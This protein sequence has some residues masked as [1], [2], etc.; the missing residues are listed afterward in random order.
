[1]NPTQHE[2][3]YALKWYNSVRT[4]LFVAFSTLVGIIAIFIYLY[5]PARLRDQALAGIKEQAASFGEFLAFTISPAIDLDDPASGETAMEAVQLNEVV[6][7][8][9]VR[10]K[11][12]NL[13]T[14]FGDTTKSAQAQEAPEEGM[15]SVDGN[16][17]LT[18]TPVLHEKGYEVGRLYVGHSLEKMKEDVR[19][20]QRVIALISFLIFIVGVLVVYW[21]SS[22]LTRNLSDIVTVV[23][24]IGAGDFS[25]RAVV[26]SQD[27][28]GILATSF[29][30]M[31]TDLG[32]STLALRKREE[33][34]RSL[35]ESMNEG[36][37][38]MEADLTIRYANPRLC[39]MLGR[40]EADLV[41][42]HLTVISGDMELP[43]FQEEGEGRQIELQLRD[44]NDQLLWILLSYSVAQDHAGAV[45]IT[46]IFTDITVLKKTERD[47]VYKNRELDTFVYKAS[48]DLKAPLSSLS[49]LVDIAKSDLTEDPSA[50]QYLTLIQRTVQKMDDVLQGLLE[51][52]WIKQGAL[53]P[54]EIHVADLVQTILRSI[55]HAPGYDTVTFQMEIPER[56]QIVSD[57]K[58][59]N[60]ILQN[61]I[62]N[63]V[64]YH[65]DEGDDKWVSI[66]V[67][68]FPKHARIAIR[69]NGPGIP[70]AAQDR[71]FDMFYRASNKSKG[72]GLGLYIVKT[73]IEKMGG[74]VTLTSELGVGTEFVVE[75][76]KMALPTP[77][78]AQA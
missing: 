22:L 72:S 20:S 28:V 73:S 70:A 71:L 35:A 23:H 38:Q 52:T 30:S 63:A 55:E 3:T 8:V 26:A 7:F 51:V 50:Q 47:L 46:A 10:D 37:L 27:E 58:I 76:P 43:D 15:L 2:P 77:T 4:R 78:V 17:W 69:D 18:S 68:D 48:H 5:F 45:S 44:G 1:M 19:Q 67:V 74:S 39:L 24:R 41:G 36:L 61:L 13:F 6:S 29:N 75:L 53:D 64:K 25:Q 56:Y 9:V 11:N 34:F 66:T 57:I 21:V 40:K 65:R 59:L 60:S 49:G 62:F 33:Q 32:A 31:V 12:G 42:K 54:M 14:S 16:F